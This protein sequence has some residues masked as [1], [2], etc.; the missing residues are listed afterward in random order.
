MRA[1]LIGIAICCAGCGD[2][3]STGASAPG[4][5]SAEHREVG[6]AAEEVRIGQPEY[7]SRETTLETTGKVAF[8]E[9]Q[10]V[11]ITAP[12]TGR[13]VE[14]LARPGDVVEPGRR[15]LVLDSP[16]AAQARADYAKAVAD[17]ERAGRALD[18]ARELFEMRA[19]AQKEVRE[20]ENDARK[21]VAERDRAAAR[22]RTLGVSAAATDGGSTVVVTAPRAGVVV[23]RNVSPGQVVAYGQSDTPLS[24]FV[25]ADLGSMW[26]LADVYEPDV[27]RVKPG[28]RVTVTLPCCPGERFDGQVVSVGDV[29]DKESRTLKVRVLVPNRGRS[30]KAEMFVRVSIGTGARQALVLPVGAIH[31]EGS[32]P[33][34]LVERG[35]DDYERRPVKLGAES[36]GTVEILDGVTPA[37]RVVTGGGILLKRAAR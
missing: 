30:L 22:L 6:A 17:A 13:V 11:R 31:R 14:V 7:R 4:A 19:T 36:D 5:S 1:L 25:V 28:Q 27:P 26:V 8:N 9:E 2:G 34:V 29:I 10:V 35:K 24:L 37:E 16:D 15:L 3:T 18:L 32:A 23:E 20:A 33:F 12:V 21:A